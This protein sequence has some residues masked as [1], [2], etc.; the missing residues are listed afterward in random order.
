MFRKPGNQQL[1][2][3][4]SIRLYNIHWIRYPVDLTFKKVLSF[5]IMIDK[6]IRS[7]FLENNLQSS[8]CPNRQQSK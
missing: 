8:R 1:F 6:L 3:F 7:F 5:C 2:D 4:K